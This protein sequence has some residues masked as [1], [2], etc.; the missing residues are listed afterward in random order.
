MI[1]SPKNIIV[2]VVIIIVVLILVVEDEVGVVVMV[3][4]IIVNRNKNVTECKHYGAAIRLLK[5]RYMIEF[6]CYITR[7]GLLCGKK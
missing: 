4:T 5:D 3:E 7:R 6:I 1:K 2:I